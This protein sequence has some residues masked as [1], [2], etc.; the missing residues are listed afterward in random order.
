MIRTLA[1]SVLLV[2]VTACS[3]AAT[4]EEKQTITEAKK[5]GKVFEFDGF[6]GMGLCRKKGRV[7]CNPEIT[8]EYKGKNYCFSSEEARATFVRDIDNNIQKATSE[9]AALGGGAR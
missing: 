5:E 6:C 4:R 8:H 1:L 7:P 3:T 9:H 2:G